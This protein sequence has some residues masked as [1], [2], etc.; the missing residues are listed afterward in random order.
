MGNKIVDKHC[1]ECGILMEQVN[2]SKKYCDNCKKIKLKEN[3]KRCF[4]KKNIHKYTENE[5]R[6]N[7]YKFINKPENLTTTGFNLLSDLKVQSYRNYFGLIWADILRMYDKFDY[8]YEY[9]KQEYLLF[10][11][12]TGSQNLYKF[13]E[14]HKYI[15]YLFIKSICSIDEFMNDCGIK[16][17]KPYTFKELKN[18]F[19]NIKNDLGYIPNYTEFLLYS[20]IP[21][22]TYANK[23]KLKGLVYDN[24][25]NMYFC[26]HEINEY[27]KRK[28]KN[29]FERIVLNNISN[30]LNCDYIPQAYFD[31]LISD[32]GCYLHVDG[33]FKEY[34]LII[35]AD[36]QQHKK[37][38]NY[39]G[40]EEKFKRQKINDSLKNKLIPK[41]G[42]KLIRI[43]ID[44]DWENIDYLKNL[45]IENNISAN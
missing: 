30:I 2:C 23:F 12:S 21:V 8:V 15:T 14:N 13:C 44:S 6:N 33:L 37:P 34:N 39:F 20:K 25:I 36:G 35:E 9:I 19:L 32:K 45:L 31:W 5:Y 29:Q 1:V 4:M 26:E 38:I 18:N 24:I 3:Q 7:F 10:Y 42:Y 11:N 28:I 16:K 43:D 27:Q 40:G 41:H 22:E 17:Q